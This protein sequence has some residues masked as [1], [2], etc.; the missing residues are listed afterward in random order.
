MS[1]NDD[2][3]QVLVELKRDLLSRF[4]VAGWNQFVEEL[5]DKN[6]L[7]ATWRPGE[8]PPA[9]IVF[10]DFRGLRMRNRH[11]DG[12]HLGVA[13]LEG[14]DFSGSSLRGAKLGS[15][16][17]AL[18]TGARLH[19]ADFEYCEISGADFTDASGIETAVFRRSSYWVG[20]PPVGLPPSVLA[21]CD[22]S[23]EP[24]T[25]DRRDQSHKPNP[26][27][28]DESPVRCVATICSTPMGEL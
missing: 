18:F 24:P 13:S 25:T 12:I 14:A 22:P 26:A 19:G 15:C 1:S 3:P 6:I 20:N 16:R 21:K 7:A 27:A 23:A 8:R 5:I 2:V 28:T 17:D 4:D 9:L 10:L 11:L